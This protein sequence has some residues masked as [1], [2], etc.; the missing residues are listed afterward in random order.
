MNSFIF[1]NRADCPTEWELLKLPMEKSGSGGQRLLELD[2]IFGNSQ[3]SDE[4][5]RRIGPYLI[6]EA[7]VRNL[8]A[9]GLPFPADGEFSYFSADR[10]TRKDSHQPLDEHLKKLGKLPRGVLVSEKEK[11]LMAK[12]IGKR[13]LDFWTVIRV[14]EHLYFHQVRELNLLVTTRSRV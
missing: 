3:S 11:K 2:G 5:C 6:D 13:D 4:F 9:R 14:Y 10:W 12:V 8:L 1:S 7:L